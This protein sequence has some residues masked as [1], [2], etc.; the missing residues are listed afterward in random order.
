MRCLQTGKVNYWTGDEGQRFEKEFADYHGA[1]YG[2]ALANG[3]VALELALIAIGIQPGDEVI[4]TPRS[5]VA[6]ASCVTRVGGTPV[7]VDV[8]RDSQ[9]IAPDSIAAAITDRTK[10]IIAVHLAGWPCDMPAICSLAGEHGV[11]VIEDCAQ[12]HGASIDGRLVGSFGDVSAFSFCQDKIMST[13]G[14]GG[15]LLTDDESLWRT[16]W[17]FK[18]HGKSLERV[19]SDDHAPGFRWL[20]ESIGTNWR[21]TEVQAAIGRI[22]LGKLERWLQARAHNAGVLI[23]A[24][25]RFPSLRVP[26]PDESVRHAYYKLYAF[27]RPER[28]R[29]GW[30]RDRILAELE[31][32]G[33]PGRSGSCP[34][35]YREK[36]FADIRIGELPVASELGE[37]SIMLPVHPTLMQD[38]LEFM[39]D[40]LAAVLE[41]ATQYDLPAAAGQQ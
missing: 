9:N 38:D 22:Q 33:V 12:A 18:D 35:I 11:F 3:T 32:R 4:V 36:A 19:Y 34:E 25:A 27:V 37:T 41:Q 17:A 8:D 24:L 21:M 31:K 30:S 28:L 13:G 26:L 5:F 20:H 6:S 23:E 10:A 39:V 1:R 7:F 14:E 15:M 40:N 29:R 16:A 2:V